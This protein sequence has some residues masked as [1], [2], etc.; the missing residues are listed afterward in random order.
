LIRTIAKYSRLPFLEGKVLLLEGYDLQLARALVSGVDVWLNNPVHPLEASGTSG[1]KAGMNGVINLSVLDG[2][3]AEGYDGSNGWAIKPAAHTLDQ[4]HRNREESRALYEI[5]QDQV[6]PM[7]YDRDAAGYSPKWVGLAKRS[8]ASI[9]PRY[10]ATRMVGEYVSKFY[11]SA[12]VHGRRYNDDAY[13][14][15]KAVAAWKA[16]VRAA[17]PGVA[18][19][20]VDVPQSRFKFG[21]SVRL[22]VAVTLNGLAPEDVVVELL[23][24][25]PEYESAE[26]KPRQYR[27]A[28]EG[29]VDSG[30]KR[31][32]VL[33]LA[34]DICGRLDYRIR[35]YPWHELLTHP[36]ELG[37][38]LWS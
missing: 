4:A 35:A 21:Q 8:I 13:A 32:F 7:Y 17:W 1:M 9:L 25:V 5:L 36:F 12:A 10:N 22:E 27:F 19:R 30:G 16:C 31:R 18:L 20:R 14:V 28:A 6:I 34:P 38:M 2:W 24:G 3:W 37:L 26:E 29:A 33:E 23:L 15:A 11:S